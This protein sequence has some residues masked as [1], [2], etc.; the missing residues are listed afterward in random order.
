MSKMPKNKKQ[1]IISFLQKVFNPE[2]FTD[3]L[4]PNQ[5][6]FRAATLIERVIEGEDTPIVNLEKEL[7][8]SVREPD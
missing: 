5:V 7:M 2:Q 1:E 6:A 4:S 3:E 8:V